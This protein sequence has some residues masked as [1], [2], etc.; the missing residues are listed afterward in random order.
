MW[1]PNPLFLGER[2]ENKIFIAFCF[3][4]RLF[5]NVFSSV[6]VASLRRGQCEEFRSERFKSEHLDIFEGLYPL[7]LCHFVSVPF[8]S[9]VILGRCFFFFPFPF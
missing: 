9:L 2:N 1:V 5:I 8:S 6:S 4:S 3:Y 7:A